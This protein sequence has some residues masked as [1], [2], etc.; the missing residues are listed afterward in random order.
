MRPP[1]VFVIAAALTL[2]AALSALPAQMASAQSPS[3]SV[4]VPSSGAAL[5]GS[6]YLDASATNATSVKFLLFGG[7]YGYNAPVVCTATLTYYGW[8][9]SWNTRTVP[10]S[11][12]AL[13]SEA[14]GAGGSAF[15][16][17]ISMTVNNPLN[18][19]VGPF[20]GT[21]S[22][23]GGCSFVGATFTAMYSN[24]F[25][26]G[27][28][29][30]EMNG[31]YTLISETQFDYSGIFTFTTNVGTL[32]GTVEGQVFNQVISELPPEIEPS[33]ASLELA[34]TSGT[35]LFTGTT[36]TLNV[37]L[38]PFSLTTFSGLVTVA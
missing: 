18:D 6:T 36:G 31:C 24:N 37:S 34:A 3:T 21:L 4:L 29:T 7:S 25:P 15:S 2:G 8:I 35:G 16:T 10:N 38:G 5:S 33:S 23:L 32:S 27:T 9:C 26:V 30:L 19:L 13:V 12:Y 11:S 22:G 17:P 20:V 14:S 28:V 1:R